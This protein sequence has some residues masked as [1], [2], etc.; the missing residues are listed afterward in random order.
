MK[1]TDPGFKPPWKRF[2][3]HRE[4]RWSLVV[5][6]QEQ[7]KSFMLLNNEDFDKD[8]EE[9]LEPDNPA[10]QIIALTRQL[11]LITGGILDAFLVKFLGVTPIELKAWNDRIA[12][13]KPP[14]GVRDHQKPTE[15][16][17]AKP[18]KEKQ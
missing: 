11:A 6:L 16:L 13:G 3:M 14:V 1:K 2:G 12:A 10:H 7:R 17:I 8:I 4:E 15:P 9:K 5:M 18:P